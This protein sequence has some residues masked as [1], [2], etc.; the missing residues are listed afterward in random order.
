MI[1]GYCYPWNSQK[2]K[3]RF[4]IFLENNFKAQWNFSTDGFAIDPN[5]FEQVGCIHSTQGLEF[6]YVGIIIGLDLR[7]SSCVSVSL[8][9][10]MVTGGMFSKGQS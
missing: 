5:S 6:D 9:E 2:D 1:A 8:G 7:L 10:R 4:D 3:S